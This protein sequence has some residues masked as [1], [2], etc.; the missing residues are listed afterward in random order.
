MEFCAGGEL[1]TYIKE[2]NASG[3]S[4]AVGCFESLTKFFILEAINTVEYMHRFPCFDSLF[5]IRII[6]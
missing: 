2:S 6:D 1:W 4:A 3:S 5:T